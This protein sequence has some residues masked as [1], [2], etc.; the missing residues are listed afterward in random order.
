M[1]RSQYGPAAGTRQGA[2]PRLAVLKAPQFIRL[3][4]AELTFLLH[5][6]RDSQALH[7]YLL[8]CAHADFRSGE[9]CT[10]YARFIE[11]MTPPQP[12]RG[13][14]RPGPSYPQVRRLVDDLEAMNLVR[15]DR[16]QNAAHGQLR[17]F[18]TPRDR[19]E[20]QPTPTAKARRI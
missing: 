8:L 19:R 10:T 12:E 4:Q 15:R 3:D 17:L 9:L 2:A 16:A 11:L 7:L 1:T 6:L 13:R 5:M 20:S 14:R 18:I